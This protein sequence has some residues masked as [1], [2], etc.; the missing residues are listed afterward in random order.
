M[1]KNN[2]PRSIDKQIVSVSELIYPEEKKGKFIPEVKSRLRSKII[3]VPE[4]SY[5][6]SE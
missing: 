2:D 1:T 3:K 6:A 5:K 4:A